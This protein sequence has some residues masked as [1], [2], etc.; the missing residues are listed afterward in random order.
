MISRKASLVSVTA[1][2]TSQKKMP[3]MLDSITRRR[4]VSL[5]LRAC[6]ASCC[7]TVRSSMRPA[8]ALMPRCSSPISSS[9]PACA[10]RAVRSPC[11]MRS[12]QSSAT[13]TRRISQRPNRWTTTPPRHKA[14]KVMPPIACMN[15][16]IGA[17]ISC[18]DTATPITHPTGSSPWNTAMRRSPR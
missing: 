7:E 4:R 9:T 17:Y 14:P 10:T 2:D 3:I 15:R 6:C 13:R 5:A 16:T 12:T 1:P 11:S 8:I 18:C